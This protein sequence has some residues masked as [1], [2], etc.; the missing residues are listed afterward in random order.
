MIEFVVDGRSGGS[1]AQAREQGRYVEGDIL[2]LGTF[3]HLFQSIIHS[4]RVTMLQASCAYRH[5]S[6]GNIVVWAAFIY[7]GCIRY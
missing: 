3:D 4:E 2:T 1:V 5:P 7:N 6:S